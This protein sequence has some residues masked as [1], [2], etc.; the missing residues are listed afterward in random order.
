MLI[1]HEPLHLLGSPI[2]LTPC[3]TDNQHGGCQR[4]S[5]LAFGGRIENARTQLNTGKGFA[6]VFAILAGQRQQH[7][8][9]LR[10]NPISIDD[11]LKEASGL[12]RI[13]MLR[14]GGDKIL[15]LFACTLKIMNV[16]KNFGQLEL[17]YIRGKTFAV[18]FRKQL[19]GLTHL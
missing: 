7:A 12:A 10:V 15:Q 18:F 14:P 9:G 16:I 4:F 5:I 3:V 2:R 13:G 1:E 19:E 8:D 6:P 17:Q 11:L